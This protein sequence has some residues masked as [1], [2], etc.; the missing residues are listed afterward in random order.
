MVVDDLH[1]EGVKVAPGEADAPLIVDADAP[2]TLAVAA[3]GFQPIARGR[4]QIVEPRGRVDREQLGAGPPLD[5][6]RQ[7]ADGVSGED[8][9]CAF[10]GKALD[11]EEA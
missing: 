6:L 10:V 3:Q 5:L 11:H 1:V 7:I 4:P 2:L 9:R 8:C